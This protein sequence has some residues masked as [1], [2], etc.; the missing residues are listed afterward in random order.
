MFR[1]KAPCL[2]AIIKR[3]MKMSGII[4]ADVLVIINL[5]VTYFILLGASFLS[6][7]KPKRLRLVLSSFFGGFYA[8][9]ILLPYVNSFFD[10]LIKI[11]AVVL[12]VLIAFGL[13]N[14]KTFLRLLVSYLVCNFIFAGLMF[15]LWYFLNPSGMFYNGTVVYFNIDVL[16][17]VVFTVVCYGFMRAF[18][19]IFK[20]R[21]PVNTVFYCKVFLKG[22][23][24]NLKAFLDTGNNLSDPFSG[25]PIIIANKTLFI[26]EFDFEN[27]VA[28]E[29]LRFVLCNTVSGKSLLPASSPER[30]IAEGADISFETDKVMIAFTAEKLFGGEYDAILPVGLLNQ[31][32]ERKD[33][34]ESEKNAVTF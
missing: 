28:G 12:P 7:E 15:L 21:A 30:I 14:A 2:N 13:K 1:H 34:R 19:F 20:S 33:E 23:Q 10:F 8:L 22:K 31:T 24:Y 32:Y 9:L 5:Y 27:P 17:L 26:S 6:H 4:Y 18:D 16:T 29:G 3:V 25:K 11:G